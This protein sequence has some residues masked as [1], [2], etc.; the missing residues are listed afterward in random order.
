MN[1]ET[2]HSLG[3]VLLATGVA[4]FS[5]GF[6]RS[7]QAA[8]KSWFPGFAWSHVVGPAL[9]FILTALLFVTAAAGF[10]ALG[11]GVRAWQAARRQ[12]AVDAASMRLGTL[13][14]RFEGV[15]DDLKRRQVTAPAP[16]SDATAEAIRQSG[17]TLAK[18]IREVGQV[19][20]TDRSGPSTTWGLSLPLVLFLVAIGF[21]VLSRAITKHR[22]LTLFAEAAGIVSAVLAALTF[23]LA[24]RQPEP[25]PVQSFGIRSEVVQPLR[26]FPPFVSASS[27][28]PHDQLVQAV[29]DFRKLI[30]GKDSSLAVVVGRHDV[31][32][33]LPEASAR[34]GSNSGL[35]QQRA[36]EVNRLLK[37]QGL[38]Q[39]DPVRHTLL[40]AG[41]P[42]NVST[43]AEDRRVEVYGLRW[44]L[45]RAEPT[46]P[47]K[48]RP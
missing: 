46:S 26:A 47:S 16:L 14:D 4:C 18:A 5:L 6:A 29:C 32:R 2:F 25:G 1:P 12:D 13:L 41:G 42:R 17:A 9:P 36:E 43:S 30:T 8:R 23:V 19:K 38:C 10:H 34:F 35:A 21:Y 7:V 15:L 3:L 20:P 33:L 48:V 11:E 45:V 24:F 44:E 27:T 31:Q 39:A 40:V 22:W 37:A 28:D